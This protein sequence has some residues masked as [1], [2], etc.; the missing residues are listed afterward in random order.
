M[1][2]TDSALVII[3]E[4]LKRIADVLEAQHKEALAKQHEIAKQLRYGDG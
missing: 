3:A 4:Q 2:R 1:Q